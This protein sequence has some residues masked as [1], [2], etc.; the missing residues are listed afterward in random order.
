MVQPNDLEYVTAYERTEEDE[1]F[2]LFFLYCTCF[3]GVSGLYA[4]MLYEGTQDVFFSLSVSL[5]LFSG[6]ALML[7]AVSTGE[8]RTH[9]EKRGVYVE[10][11]LLKAYSQ[12]KKKKKSTTQSRKRQ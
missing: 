6:L 2:W 3:F 1:R 8:V 11:K 5:I 4:R 12:K 10:K 9:F 7:F